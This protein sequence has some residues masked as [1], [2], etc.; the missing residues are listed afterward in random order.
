[1]FENYGG[2]IVFEGRCAIGN[3]SCLSIG[4]SGYVVF[5]DSFGAT[6]AFRLISYHHVSFE[7]NVLFGWECIVSDTDLHQLHRIDNITIRNYG[8]I[9]IAKCCWIAMRCIILKNSKLPEHCV[10]SASSLICK[11][12]HQPYSMLGGIPAVIIKEGI[13]RDP[14]NDKIVYQGL[15][16]DES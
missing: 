14:Y 1:M 16:E 11:Q 5:G 15:Y 6:S 8:E 3:D 2:T 9:H 13:Y 7:E 12:F 10:V 4:E